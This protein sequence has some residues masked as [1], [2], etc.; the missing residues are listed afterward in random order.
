MK[1]RIIVAAVVL[2]A[3]CAAGAGAQG[4][5]PGGKPI[6]IIVPYSAGGLSDI[7]ARF[8]S[9]QLEAKFGSPFVVVNKPGA[10]AQIGLTELV[11]SKPDGYTIGMTNFPTVVVC[12][13]DKDRK[14]IFDRTSFQPIAGIT[15][16]PLVVAVNAKSP[17]Y[18]LKDLVA[19]AKASPKPMVVSS[20]GVLSNDHLSILDLQKA[21]GAQFGIIH[22]DGSGEAITALV[23]QKTQA[24][25][26]GAGSIM[27]QVTGGNARIIAVFANKPSP[28]LP[29]VATAEAQGYPVYQSGMIAISAP[30]KT[31]RNVVDTLGGAIDEIM[32]T[33]VY[34]D[35][36]A[37]LGSPINYMDPDTL[38]TYWKQLEEITR[39]LIEEA[40]KAK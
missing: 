32:K 38:T 11:R 31:P 40:K 15:D 19:A 20:G 12:Y 35:K 36:L 33:Q 13:L 18:S 29:G 6:T 21:S 30:A 2:A 10:G 24:F 27:P 7:I 3:L 4:N 1:G 9:Q 28:S 39:P 26:G 14:A 16:T 25:F 17:Y 23:G 5:Y 22:F 34:K 8:L 37:S